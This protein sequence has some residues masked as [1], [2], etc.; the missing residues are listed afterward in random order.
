LDQY[1]IGEPLRQA[2]ERGAGGL[3]DADGAGELQHRVRLNKR[4]TLSLIVNNVFDK[5]KHDTTGGWPNYPVGSHSPAG[6]AGGV[7]LNYH[8]GS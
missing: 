3:P 1:G 5:I 6:R 4:T 7:E 8:F 2:A